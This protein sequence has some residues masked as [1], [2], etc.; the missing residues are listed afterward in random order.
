VGA[1]DQKDR[2]SMDIERFFSLIRFENEEKIDELGLD[3]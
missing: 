2:S 3:I 1:K